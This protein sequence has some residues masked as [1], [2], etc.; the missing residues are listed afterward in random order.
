MK[1]TKRIL[2]F[3]GA[4]LLIC[5]YLCTLAAALVNFSWA[6]D[7]LKASVAGTILIPVLLYGYILIA[8]LLSNNSEDE[9]KH[10]ESD[11]Q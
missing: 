5:M 3:T 7:L 6:N 4:L 9:D 11:I 10:N 1:K 8:R 2:A